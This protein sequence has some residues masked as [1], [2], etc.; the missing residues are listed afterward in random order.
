MEVAHIR[1]NLSLPFLASYHEPGPYASKCLSLEA[2]YTV[3]SNAAIQI[4]VPAGC[5]SA[6]STYSAGNNAVMAPPLAPSGAIGF[7]L[8]DETLFKGLINEAE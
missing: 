4:T 2:S 1:S 8:M 7:G 6:T 3:I 5:H